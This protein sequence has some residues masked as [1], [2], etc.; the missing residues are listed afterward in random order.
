MTDPDRAE[1]AF[2]AA[3]SELDVPLA[4]DPAA[5]RRR[6]RD[7]RLTAL[8]VVATVLVAA[9]VGGLAWRGQTG[10]MTTAARPAAEQASPLADSGPA[11]WRS[12]YYRDIRFEVPASGGQVPRPLGGPTQPDL[13]RRH[14]QLPPVRGRVG[15]AS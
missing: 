5:A 15:G 3:I 12:E 6:V 4:P 8:A 1:R 14:G 7:R 10:A 9:V 2:R 11:G 13:A